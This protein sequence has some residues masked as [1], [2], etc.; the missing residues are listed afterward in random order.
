MSTATAATPAT[1]SSAATSRGR[2]YE[3]SR[4]G[5]PP[6]RLH[7]PYTGTVVTFPRGAESSK[8]VQIDHVVALGDAWQKGAQQLTPQ[9]APKPG[10]RSP[11]PHRRGRSGQPGEERLGRRHLAAKNKTIRCHY[12]ARQIS[13]KASYGLWVTQPEKDAMERVLE[14]CPQQQTIAARGSGQ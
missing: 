13:V 6:V 2:V 12:V 5:S 1:T 3:G 7:E 4:A 10:Q 11:K 14:S 9:A 8:D